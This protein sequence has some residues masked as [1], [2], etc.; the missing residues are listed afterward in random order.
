VLFERNS[1]ECLSVR[2][3]YL[4]RARLAR[5]QARDEPSGRVDLAIKVLEAIRGRE[6]GYQA[7]KA[8]DLNSTELTGS[9][10]GQCA[11][12]PHLRER[13]QKTLHFLT[14]SHSTVSSFRSNLGCF[15]AVCCKLLQGEGVN[16]TRPSWRLRL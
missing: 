1:A 13:R 9:G 11:V 16:G 4:N 2:K 3:R 8:Q 5:G 7:A 10:F 15:Y 12:E 14:F 6:D